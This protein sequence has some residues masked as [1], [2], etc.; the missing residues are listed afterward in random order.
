MRGLSQAPQQLFLTF[1]EIIKMQN[2]SYNTGP[3]GDTEEKVSLARVHLP[4]R[5]EYCQ[6]C[7]AICTRCGQPMEKDTLMLGFL[8]ESGSYDG[9]DPLFHHI[10]C[11][12]QVFTPISVAEIRHFEVL[13]YEDQKMLE[14][15]IDSKGQSI[16]NEEE[17]GVKIA[18]ENYDHETNYENFRVEY[19][20]SDG[21]RCVQ[22]DYKIDKDSVRLVKL[23]LDTENQ[24]GGGPIS[25][26]FHVECFNK[27][28]SQLEFYGDVRRIPHFDDLEVDDQ[29]MLIERGPK[30]KRFKFGHRVKEEEGVGQSDE[31]RDLQVQS[32]RFFALRSIVST[33][34][35]GDIQ[36]MLGLMRQ[37]YTCESTSML[38]NMATDVLLFG[39]ISEC[40]E[41]K[42]SASMVLRGSCY[43]C[44]KGKIGRAHV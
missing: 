20:K 37:R 25:R 14:G 7:P 26:W 33:M 18:D 9:Y 6:T 30:T 21:S 39:P 16:C 44:T 2:H 8:V 15:A 3:M 41:C 22:C 31:D 12:F 19:A 5:A 40:P 32:D 28:R 17:D 34:D 38:I 42:Q 24:W 36:L 27:S 23:D 43:I 10:K 1:H 35:R 29:D 13:R 11:F 4:Y